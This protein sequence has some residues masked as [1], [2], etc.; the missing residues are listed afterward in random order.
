MDG[1]G[2]CATGAESKAVG[3]VVGGDAL[4]W[5]RPSAMPKGTV[6]F[7]QDSYSRQGS[8][9]GIDLLTSGKLPRCV[10]VKP[11]TPQQIVS[12]QAVQPKATPNG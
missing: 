4:F 6:V 1:R 5:I 8:I 12:P 10:P 2:T 9:A 7:I 11:P 3:V